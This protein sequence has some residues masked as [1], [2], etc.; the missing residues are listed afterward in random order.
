MPPRSTF[1]SQ[2]K[3]Y[4]DSLKD[5]SE[6]LQT[7]RLATLKDQVNQHLHEWFPA[8]GD[9]KKE[10]HLGHRRFRVLKSLGQGGYST[11]YLV[12]EVTSFENQGH[13]TSGPRFAL[14]EV[15]TQGQDQLLEAEREIE[16]MK[17][18]GHPKLMPILDQ[19]TV[20]RARGQ[21]RYRIVYMLFPLYVGDFM[22]G[23]EE[24]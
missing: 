24:N 21:A 17:S 8:L 2:L 5:V 18:L 6:R 22:C 9:G 16:V 4:A 7:S 23:A 12:E 20:S 10:V 15:I 19:A 14:K 13:G 1:W 3:G 11:V